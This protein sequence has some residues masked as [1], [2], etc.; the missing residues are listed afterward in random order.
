MRLMR[1]MPEQKCFKSETNQINFDAQIREIK[2]SG[3]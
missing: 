3:V 2:S 1:L